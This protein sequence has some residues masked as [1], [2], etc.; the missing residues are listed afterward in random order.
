MRVLVA[1]DEPLIADNLR[2]RSILALFFT[3]VGVIAP[4][5]TPGYPAR[6]AVSSSVSEP[7]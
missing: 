4:R 3:T 7:A 6:Y 5:P 2:R 1:E